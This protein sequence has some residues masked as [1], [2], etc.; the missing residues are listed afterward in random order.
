MVRRLKQLQSVQHLIRISSAWVTGKV[1]LCKCV[2]FSICGQGAGRSTVAREAQLTTVR[3]FSSCS[4]GCTTWNFRPVFVQPFIPTTSFSLTGT[5]ISRG[6]CMYT[7]R[8]PH[9]LFF[10]F[11]LE[12]ECH[13]Y[14]G[15]AVKCARKHSQTLQVNVRYL[16]TINAAHFPHLVKSD[17]SK[18]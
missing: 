18:S 11:Y 2:P 9:V 4:K 7:C 13:P 8:Y 5:V 12:A 14:C 17:T 16:Y 1:G 10:F 6:K 3:G 15:M